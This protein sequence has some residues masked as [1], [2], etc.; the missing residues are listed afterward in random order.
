MS[1]TFSLVDSLSLGDLQVYLS[2]AGRIEDGSVRL[3]SGSGVLAVY[4][5]VI[6]P[7]GLLDESPTIL[8]LRTFALIGRDDFDVVVPVRSLLERLTRLQADIVDPTAPV[9]V[10]LPMQV[11][12]VT[13]AA[14]SPPKGGWNRIGE[15]P[16]GSL[17]AVGRAGIDEVAAAVPDGTGEQIVRRV[18]TEVW[19]R[20]IEGLEYVPAGAGFAAI[21]LGFLGDSFGDREAVRIYET[22]PWTRLTSQRGHVL[23][24]RRAWSLQR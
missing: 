20:P 3:I 6:Y 15:F 13:W 8:G 23:V 5:A 17:D 9:T 16:S 4:V 24:K 11:N 7:S 18:R 10:S 21:T 14:I 22:G 2:R 19:G 1:Q 12:T